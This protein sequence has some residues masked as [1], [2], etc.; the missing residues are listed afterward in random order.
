M[1]PSLRYLAGTAGPSGFGSRTT[2]EEATVA[3]RDL[4]HITAIITGATSGIGAETA[5]VLARRGARLVL[6]ARSLK[7]AEE[8]RARVRA[9][10][11]GA[12]VAVLPLDLS[13]L[14]SVR[15]FVKRFLDLG[16][17]LNLLVYVPPCCLLLLHP[18]VSPPSPATTANIH[19]SRAAT[20]PAST[21]TA[22]PCRR[23]AWR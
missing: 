15:R 23:T 13:S 18:S 4:G 22:S 8:A 21:P 11:P 14:A 9:E 19:D 10:C 6:P 12:D 16:L 3:G 7:A 5:R 20:T 17:P 2:A 1:L